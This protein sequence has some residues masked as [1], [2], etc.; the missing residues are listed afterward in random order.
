MP[1]FLDANEPPVFD[2]ISEIPANT[3]NFS[4]DQMSNIYWIEDG[5]LIKYNSETEEKLYY[6]DKKWGNISSFD[7][8]DP[9][10]IIVLFSDFSKIVFLDKNLSPRNVSDD[11][12][13]FNSLN[14]SLICYSRHNGFWI[15][16]PLSYKLYKFDDNFKLEL[17]GETLNHKFPGF[18]DPYYMIE[19]ED[20]LFISDPSSGI[21]VFD[22]FANFLFIIPLTNITFFQV[23]ENSILYFNDDQM[24][25][26]DFEESIEEVYLLPEDG[27]IKGYLYE[28]SLY[29][30]TNDFI[31]HYKI[32]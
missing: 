8:S 4:V 1:I 15:F 31:K 16:S 28:L 13:L 27:V 30:L 29:L 21:W 2:F 6:S 26:H 17:E 14:P 19:S 12:S 5:G 22:Q 20:K 11:D 9:L 10:N 18:S 23:K 32:K 3:N 7:S 24:S 25:L